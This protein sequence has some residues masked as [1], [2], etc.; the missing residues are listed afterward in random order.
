MLPA[1]LS[2]EASGI[3]ETEVAESIN[4]L[5]SIHSSDMEGNQQWNDSSFFNAMI[6]SSDNLFPQHRLQVRCKDSLRIGY[7]NSC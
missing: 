5:E 1:F 4:L 6:P 7:A 2:H 3:T